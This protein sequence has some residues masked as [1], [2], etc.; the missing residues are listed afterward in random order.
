MLPG[1]RSML[2]AVLSCILEMV[3]IVLV[4]FSSRLYNYIYYYG[5]FL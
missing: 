4:C 3:A 5:E 2:M 1:K